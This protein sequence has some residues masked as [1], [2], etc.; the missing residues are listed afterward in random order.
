MNKRRRDTVISS[1]EALQLCDNVFV[2]GTLK[3][4]RGNHGLL[5]SATFDGTVTTEESFA[6]GDIGFPYAFPFSVVP[7][8]LRSRLCWPV[9]GE[10]YEVHDPQTMRSLDSLEGFPSHYDRIV[11]RLSNGRQAWMYVQDDWDCASWCE[12]CIYKEG[13]W[14]W[15]P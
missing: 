11:V 12:A 2:Y 10:V 13:V 6:L 1:E 14:E 9:R 7:R 3:Y 4:G 15:E 5:S 8:E